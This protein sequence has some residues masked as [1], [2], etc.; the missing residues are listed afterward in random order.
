[1]GAARGK[2]AHSLPRGARALPR[3]PDRLPRSGGGGLSATH[4]RRLAVA[5]AVSLYAIVITGSLV[6]LTGSGLGC[7]GW[8]GCEEGA[9]FPEADYHAFVEFGNRVFGVFPITLSILTALFA[10]GRARWVFA[11]TLAVAVLT[12]AEA[13]LGLATIRYD[14]PAG[15]VIVHF[16]LALLALG[17]AI[18]VALEA[19]REE[20]GGAE[21]SFP[22][23]LRW[24]GAGLAAACLVLVVTGTFST[25]AG[26]HSGDADVV[27]RLWHLDDAVYLHVRVTAVFGALF[28]FVLGLLAARRSLAPRLFRSALALLGVLLLQMAV[29]ELQWR[30]ELPWGIVALHVALAA[31]V[32]SLTVALAFALWRPPRWLLPRNA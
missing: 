8:P 17:G 23:E 5:T 29:G 4:F 31:G 20:R 22:R 15:M 24:A 12:V 3:H 28:L 6:R 13:P 19:V 10:R 2:L 30:L 14:L 11:T 1:M 9:F 21:I 32:W 27:E 26:P 7:E 25:A 16:L 18:V